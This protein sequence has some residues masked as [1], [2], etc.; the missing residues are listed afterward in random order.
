M[1]KSMNFLKLQPFGAS[2]GAIAVLILCAALSPAQA[3]AQAPSRRIVSAIDSSS[4]VTLSGSRPPR[5][6]AA[7]DI[8]AV[9]PDTRLE[10]MTLVFNHSAA[11][12]A[13]L[14]ALIAAQ[15]DPASPQFHQ[16]L[17]PA[18]FGARFGMADADLA[19]A[20]NWLQQ[21]GFTIDSVSPSRDRIHFS[22][23]AGLANAA[24]ATELHYYRDP[25]ETQS[26]AQPRMAPSTDISLPASLAP[27]VI[28]VTNLSGFRPHSH[29]V[30]GVQPKFTSSQTG[31]HYMTPGDV[32][33]IYDINSA[34]NAAYTGA[35]QSIAVVG[36]SAIYTS[37]ITNFQ[38]AA[39]L[40]TKLPTILLEPGT[41]N[42][43]VYSGDEIESDLDIEYSGAIA[44]GAAIYF[45]YTGSGNFGTFDALDYV[46]QNDLAPIISTSYGS[47]EPALGS[48]SYN[49]Y[50][51]ELAQAAT[52]GETVV[53]AAG[54]AGSSDCYN[55]FKPVNS[56]TLA[57][58]EQL[59]VDFPA[60]S[61]YV[62]ALGGTEFPLVDAEPAATAGSNSS[63]YWA[64][65]NGSDVVASALSYIPEQVWN[66][67]SALVGLASGGGGASMFTSRPTW[68]A[69]TV[70][71]ISAIPGTFRLVPDISLDASPSPYNAPY[72]ICTSD[73]SDWVS[74]QVSSCTSG[75]RDASSGDITIVG[76]TSVAAPIF[77]GMVAIINQARNYTGGQ[78]LVN[79]TLY[80]LASTPATYQ[81]AFHDIISGGNT[82]LAGASYC[83]GGLTSTDYVSTTGY[84]QASGLG[85]VDL[86]KLLSAWPANS[87][88]SGSNFTISNATA[89]VT[90]PGTNATASFTVTPVGGYTGSVAFRIY[91]TA[92]IAYTCF[93]IPNASITST[94]A[95][96]ATLTISTNVSTCGSGTT[97][98]V[99]TASGGPAVASAQPSTPTPARHNPAPLSAAVAGILCLALFSRRSRNKLA[100][101][102]LALGLLAVM[103]LSGLGLSGCSNGASS[104]TTTT[105]P[106]TTT[107]TTPAGGPYTI[108]VVGYNPSN[109][110]Q[111]ATATLTLTVQ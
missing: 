3:K 4:R 14:E 88:A 78:G 60:S 32:A 107:V 92:P 55:E 49:A 54:D 19:A 57:E 33:T 31:N 25:T 35:G 28:G 63:T 70:P 67:D 77:A 39:G 64:A 105:P 106:T 42:A 34:Y 102:S 45:V 109:T 74:S 101:A 72:A 21:Q 48:S 75:F 7:N 76:G 97:P 5:A 69:N 89:T 13:D 16:W 108:T 93:T 68:Q 103:A 8:G 85:S 62:T 10:G 110:S 73:T 65:A 91:S 104:T 22:G 40:P 50:N 1:T 29:L 20:E 84:D 61:Q 83:S 36:Q 86:Y 17:T 11:Q 90:T 2:L 98:L 41:G 71:G 38:T 99:V 100:R 96:T 18:Q 30:H 82:C 58:N 26:S 23:S 81:S 44:K 37:D 9:S 59:A 95:V 111:S 52:Q 27:F 79:P 15:Q 51:N 24:F 46:V 87:V 66:D 80:S 47:C 43:T 12:Q 56:S 94:T 6:L 53:A